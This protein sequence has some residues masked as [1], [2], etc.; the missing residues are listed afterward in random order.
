M[1]HMKIH[2]G[3]KTY[4]FNMARRP[5]SEN[6]S[7]VVFQV[8]YAT[9]DI[10]NSPSQ[11]NSTGE[12]GVWPMGEEKGMDFSHGELVIIHMDSSWRWKKG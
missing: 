12:Q 2:T 4:Y 10:S 11:R 6:D 9:M 3:T 8:G 1:H 5:R 7:E